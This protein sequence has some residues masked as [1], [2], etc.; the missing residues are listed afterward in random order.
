MRA[1]SSR[2]CPTPR[3]F[4]PWPVCAFATGT[5]HAGIVLPEWLVSSSV[6]SRLPQEHSGTAVSLVGP[7][8]RSQPSAAPLLRKFQFLPSP[9]PPL[10]HPAYAD[11]SASRQTARWTHANKGL[12]A[13][14]SSA[15]TSSSYCLKNEVYKIK[16]IA[17]MSGRSAPMTHSS[18]ARGTG[19]PSSTKALIPRSPTARA[20]SRPI[21]SRTPRASSRAAPTAKECCQTPSPERQAAPAPQISPRCPLHI[22]TPETTLR[23]SHPYHTTTKSG[24]TPGHQPVP[25]AG[26]QTN[27]ASRNVPYTPRPQVHR[28]PLAWKYSRVIKFSNEE[29]VSIEAGG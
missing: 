13:S 15:S 17:R 19:N 20:P 27:L 24:Q 26:K 8:L 2:A 29:P 1:I 3:A 12:Q 22:G 28:L 16:S 6:S 21:P 5:P 9:P 11:S 18:S 7:R 4:S 10:W 23:L 25:T 14:M